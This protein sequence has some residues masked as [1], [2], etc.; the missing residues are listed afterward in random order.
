MRLKRAIR[1]YVD[2]ETGEVTLKA[3]GHQK[4]IITPISSPGSTD[5]F[6]FKAI[7]Q[8]LKMTRDLMDVN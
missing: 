1:V 7:S 4:H 6:I 2:E 5:E 8:S 3:E